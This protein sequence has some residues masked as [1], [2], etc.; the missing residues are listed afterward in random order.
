MA[1]Q[2]RYPHVYQ[3]LEIRGVTFK[4]RLWQAPPGCFFAADEHGFVTEKFVEYF[5][6]YARGGVACCTVGNCTI[7][8]N[9]SCDEPGQL[10]LSDPGCVQPLKLFTEMCE[11]YGCQASLEITHNGKDIRYDV[12]GHAPYSVSSFITPAERN[13]A[14]RAGREPQPTVEMTKEHI[15]ETVRKF[16]RAASFCKQAGMKICMVHGAHGNLIPQFASPYYNRR[17]DEYGGS[18][19]NRA[20]FAI[21][22]LDAVREAVG[23]DFVIEYRISAEEYHPQ[24]MHFDETLE[25]IE[26][27]RDRIDLLHISNGLH[28]LYGEVE[29]LRYLL[30]YFTL[31]QNLN[32]EFA[33]AVKKRFPDLPVAVV[34]AIKN[35]AAAEEIIAAG[36]ADIVAMNRALHADY[37]MPRK[38]AEGKE[39][40]H[41]PCL[42]CSMCF[43]MASPHTAKLCSVNPMWGRFAQYPDGVLPRAHEKKKVAVIGGGP[44]G[45]EAMKWLLQRGHDVTLYEK[46]E[47]LGGHVRVGVAAPFKVDLLEYLHYMED[48]ASHCGGKVLLGTEATPELLREGDYDA[49][50]AAIGAEPAIPDIPGASLPH[51]H[52]APDAD[53]GLVPC[54][55]RVVIIGGNTVGTEVAASLAMRGKQVTLIKRSADGGPAMQITKND[56]IRMAEE[57]GAKRI[58][59]LRPVEILPDRVVAESIDSGE[60]IELPC[61]TVLFATGMTPRHAEAMRFAGCCPETSFFIIGDAVRSGDVRDAVFQAFEAARAI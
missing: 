61:D 43:R 17:T 28:D 9:E 48:F 55:D 3:P 22:V 36:K 19:E 34:G 6:Q 54:G 35:V 59:G 38:Y 41:M 16:A 37:D 12:L 52:W 2:S 32:V 1:F 45:I 7:D 60:R 23:E 13:L 18:L 21:E 29:Y 53:S 5:R 51:V 25:F 47:H 27:I 20:R 24:Q 40:Q 15:H 44:G 46:S 39:W 10:E 14:A 58:C 26:L 4:N 50:I 31:P 30:P 42:R 8:I 49:I 56:L 11:A 33:A 57:H